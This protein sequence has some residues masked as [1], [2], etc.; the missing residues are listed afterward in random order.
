MPTTQLNTQLTGATA[1]AKGNTA[2]VREYASTTS[3]ILKTVNRLANGKVT[4]FGQLTG[5]FGSQPDGTW[6]Y[7]TAGAVKGWCRGDVITF[8]TSKQNTDAQAQTLM[9]ELC[10]NN[11][12]IRKTL[13]AQIPVM[14]ALKSAGRLPSKQLQ[15]FKDLSARLLKREQEIKENKGL[16]AQTG[17]VTKYNDFMN[18]Y[19]LSTLSISGLDDDDD[20]GALPAAAAWI[21]AVVVIAGLGAAVYA[22]FSKYHGESKADL[23]ISSDLEKALSSLDPTTAKKVKDDLEGQVDDAYNKGRTDESNENGGIFG[24]IKNIA[25]FGGG[26]LLAKYLLDK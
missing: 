10:N 11:M 16:K 3:K 4:A 19:G 26:I 12:A 9:N 8:S 22:Y 17:I 2:N 21:I 1:Y 6:Y 24:N 7:V 20:I 14:K 23:V 5:F 25:M 15:Q 18:K 13:V